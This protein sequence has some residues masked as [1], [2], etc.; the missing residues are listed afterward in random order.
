MERK[1]FIE[2][3]KILDDSTRVII[4]ELLSQNGT[5]CGCRLLE[6]LNITQGTLSHHMKLL[7]ENGFVTCKKEGKWCYYTID[8]NTIEE[9]SN[10]IKGLA[11]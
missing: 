6:E 1:E 10:F 2:K 5:L 4:L 11:K 7:V 9:V 8:K 3:I